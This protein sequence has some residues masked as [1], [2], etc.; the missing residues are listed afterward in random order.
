MHQSLHSLLALA[1]LFSIA[2]ASAIPTALLPRDNRDI[3]VDPTCFYD[4]GGG[5]VC[6]GSPNI[7]WC[8][9]AVNRTCTAFAAMDPSDKTNIWNIVGGESSSDQGLNARCLASV[10]HNDGEIEKTD[11]PTCV[12]KFQTLMGC[13]KPPGSD[14]GPGN[15]NYNAYCVGGSINVHYNDRYS[16]GEV[17]NR[18]PWYFLSVPHGTKG[19]GSIVHMP[20]DNTPE[21]TTGGS[22]GGSTTGST[23]N[24]GTS[25]GRL[26]GAGASTYSA[27]RGGGGV[28]YGPGA[29]GT[30]TG[31][32]RRRWGDVLVGR[33][34]S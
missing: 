18:K 6:N 11:Y 17:D 28:A 25:N 34:R 9:D 10:K 19:Q 20:G 27:N 2:L 30:F 33:I 14:G 32:R 29:A 23:Q 7:D 26:T 22:R 21:T 12:Q 31:K 8:V 4:Q 24:S 3:S 1:P 13:Q 5:V 15:K 16:A